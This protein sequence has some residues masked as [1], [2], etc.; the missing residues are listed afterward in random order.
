MLEEIKNNSEQE[1]ENNSTSRLNKDVVWKDTLA[2]LKVQ[3]SGAVYS[4]WLTKTTLESLRKN[5]KERYSA[6]IGCISTFIKQ[7]VEV[8]YFGLIQDSLI[9]VLG[10]PVDIVFT[11]SSG[12]SVL[13]T[14][15]KNTAS[16]P[17]FE[18]ETDNEVFVGKLTQSHIHPGR[19]FENY[20]VSSTNQLA[21]AACEA[22][23]KGLGTTYNPLF[24]WGG[25]GVGKTHLM[26]AIGYRVIKK[27]LNE[28]VLLCTGEDF[29][30]D[31]IAGIRTKTT[32]AFRDKYRKLKVL[33]ID[34]IQFIAGKESVQE[35]FF[36]TFNAIISAGGQ[37]VLSSDRPPSETKLED[38]LVSRFEAGLVVDIAPPDFELRSAI[39][40]IKARERGIELEDKFAQAIASNLDSARKIE[41]FL[42]K[43]IS[44]VKLKNLEVN[45][46][47]IINL[48]G[49]P[50]M[51]NGIHGFKK[52][53][54]AEAII[55]AVCAKYQINKRAMVGKA[56]ARLI[57]RPRQILMYLLRTELHLS[58]EEV[59]RLIGGRDHTTVMHAVETITQMAS[60]DSRFREDI[61]GIKRGL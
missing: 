36:H 4:T 6:E 13:K 16:V 21:W 17:L 55:D 47:L 56:R 24:I 60:N 8:R 39:V 41:G 48:L 20:A 49:R 35:E 5:G 27:N 50:S 43:L 57:A 46:E 53:L 32:Q 34:D 22:V 1:S 9:K 42:I 38:R 52:Q 26:N 12:E 30:N 3:V 11:I 40:S 7:T 15:N 58:L 44:E 23:S 28:R 51:E 59:G 25:V 14:E 45:E 18:E 10:A 2:S 33:F 37:V 19:I 54:T 31:I 61:L 29:T